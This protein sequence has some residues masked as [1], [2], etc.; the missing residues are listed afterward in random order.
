MVIAARW[1]FIV[2]LPFLLV[3]AS[4]AW[5]INSLWLYPHN[6][7]KYQVREELARAGVELSAAELEQ[8][9]ADLIDY[10]NSG[11]ESINFTVTR[12]GKPVPLFTPEEVIHFR[13]VKGLIWLDYWV[14][15]GTL[16][17]ALAY[18]GF[19]LW[20]RY[21]PEL[22]WGLVGGG[23]L[24]LALMLALGLGALFGF[25]KL[26]WQFHV[27]S[28]SNLYW[29]AEGYMHLLFPEGFFRDV[30][31]LCAAV[32]IGLGVVLAGVGGGCLLLNKKRARS[33]RLSYRQ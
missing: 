29:L 15:L 3:T 28:F 9:Y 5:A 31:I 4:L 21:L 8:I 23:S 16:A 30:T 17:Y 7:E 27:I 1:L 33:P 18:A 32:T 22:G 19:C 13:D 11:E 24:T 26:F 12:Y 6:L 2:S 10:F 20:K 14:L 25:E